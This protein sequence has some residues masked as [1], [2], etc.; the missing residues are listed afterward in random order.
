MIVTET[1]GSETPSVYSGEQISLLTQHG[2]ERVIAPVLCW[3][4]RSAAGS[5]TS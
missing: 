5:N 3:G 2:K 4:A 1:G